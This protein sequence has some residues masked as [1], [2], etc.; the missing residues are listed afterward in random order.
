MLYET[1]L[2]ALRVIAIGER[3][4]SFSAYA[5]GSG[6]A[7]LFYPSA[8]S[9]FEAVMLSADGEVLTAPVEC[10]IVL[11]RFVS[12]SGL[13]HGALSLVTSGEQ[14]EIPIFVP[15]GDG[16]TLYPV[17][18]KQIYSKT[19]VF[20]G[21]ME[22]TL[23]TEGGKSRARIIEAPSE[24]NFSDE[25][26]RRLMITEGLPDAV[27]SLAYRRVGEEYRMASTDKALT[28]DSMLPLAGLAAH[29]GASGEISIVCRER[30]LRLTV[31][32]DAIYLRDGDYFL[33]QSARREYR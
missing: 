31:S 33:G 27:R 8:R 23:Y 9:D 32:R 15:T 13:P 29:R 14:Y 18:R 22:H 10:G 7:L 12:R 25:L 26:L 20:S 24:I 6:R 21:G 3:P 16:G 1:L 5:P 30:R 2:G 11:S 17:K 28:L 19:V 4:K